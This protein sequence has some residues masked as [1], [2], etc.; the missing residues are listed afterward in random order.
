MNNLYLGVDIGGTAVKIGL[1]S[2]EG[3]VVCSDSYNVSFDCYRTPIM[4]TVQKSIPLFLKEHH[5]LPE[6]L[7]GIGVSATGQ[8]D[9]TQG[10]VA[11]TA[12]HIDNWLNTP[13][14]EILSSQLKKPVTVANDANCAVI[15]EHWKGAAAGYQNVI[16]ITIGTGIGGGIICD[17]HLLSGAMGIA[18]E[19]GHFS[20]CKDGKPCTCGSC[21][22]Y[23]QYAST[24]ALVRTVQ[25]S[26]ASLHLTDTKEADIDGR[27]IFDQIAN[28]HA[29]LTQIVNEWMDDIAVGLTGLIHIFN[30]QIVLVGG[31]V[32]RQ[33]ELF[34]APLR[35]KITAR[36]MPGFAKNLRV[37]AAALGNDAGLIGAVAYF[38]D[39]F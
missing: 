38:K 39:F 29:G 1:V 27:F 11:G 26:L 30:P 15:G 12:G 23:E 5:I 14:K 35:Q 8:I 20:I 28:G 24:S 2:E 9:V 34:I 16:M 37:E 18:A 13:V 10:V 3:S 32:S 21:G 36:V 19:L 25:S 7:T 17:S 31:G 6:A 22:C 33:K 4:D